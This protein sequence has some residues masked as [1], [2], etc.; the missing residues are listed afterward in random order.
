MDESWLVPSN[1]NLIGHMRLATCVSCLDQ[2]LSANSQVWIGSI[3][4]RL[5]NSPHAL[6][7]LSR[8]PSI[9]YGKGTLM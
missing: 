1:S 4:E 3:S 7:A 9:F 6:V 2:L 5:R 8:I